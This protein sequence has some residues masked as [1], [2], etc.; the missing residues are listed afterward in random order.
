MNCPTEHAL[1]AYID[2]E[3]D[4]TE[5]AAIKEHLVSCP[6]CPLRLETFSAAALRVAS[7]FHSLDAPPSA[8]ETNPQAALARFKANLSASEERVPFFARLFSPRWRFVWASSFAAVVLLISLL[9]PA[10]RS[11]AQRLLATL[12]VERVQTVALDFGALDNASSSRQP[13]EALAKMLSENAVVTID[14]KPSS[15]ATQAAASQAVGFP[16]RVL[17][18]RTDSP[19]F[20]IA[21]AHAFH[22]SLDRSR[23]QDVLDQAGRPDLLLP[24]SLDGATVSVQVPRAAAVKY[25]SCKHSGDSSGQAPATSSTPADPCLIVIQAPSPLINVP[26]DLNIQQLAEIGLQLVGWNPVQARQFCQSVDWRST[27]VVPISRN[28]QSYETVNINGIRGT[29]MQFSNP[30]NRTGPSFA[31]IWVDNATIYG[32]IGQGDSTSAVQL[33]SSL[34]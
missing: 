34:Q 9:F 12:R 16:V 20:K 7:R 32:L 18:N 6:A 31:L 24:A 11:F 3:L 28:V 2:N 23:L 17:P 33:A 22:L 14:E 19:A 13:L 21:G 8:A 27:L 15:A 29:L 30:H 10:T 1:R 26:S 4:P 5:I 25:G